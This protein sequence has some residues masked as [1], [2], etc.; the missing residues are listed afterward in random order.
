MVSFF[1]HRLF[2]KVYF[3]TNISDLIISADGIFLFKQK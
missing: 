2:E 1:I 3:Y